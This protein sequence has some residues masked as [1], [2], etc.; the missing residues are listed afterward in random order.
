MLPPYY[1][2]LKSGLTRGAC[3]LMILG[4]MGATSVSAQNLDVP[5]VPTPQPVVDRML[6]IANVGPGDYV[7]DLG[8]GDGRIVISAAKLGAT[9]HGIDIDPRRV[10]Q[11]RVNAEVEEVEEKV[12]FLQEDIFES[13]I[14]QATVVTMYLLTSVNQRL[15]PRL[16]SM[17]RPGTRV[18][19]HQFDMGDWQP[20]LT[21]TVESSMGRNHIIHFWVMPVNVS[22]VWNWSVEGRPFSLEVTQQY[23][24]IEVVLESDGEVLPV[25]D[26]VLRGRRI[27]FTAGDGTESYAFN[28][29]VDG[30]LITG[31]VHI[32][33]DTD[34]LGDWIA[35]RE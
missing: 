3:L 13:D 20:D 18:I 19:S 21:Y 10:S 9:G 1:S 8:S 23:Q 22:G 4:C 28:G 32:R 5:Y 24:Q 33:S 34:R 27:S 26:A 35:N 16:F 29:R 6:E 11:A 25:D 14:T 12:M 31:M 30:N 7:I 15:R 17:L 2:V